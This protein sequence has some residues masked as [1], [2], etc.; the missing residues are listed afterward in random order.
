MRCRLVF[1]VLS[2]LTASCANSLGPPATVTGVWAAAFHIPGS[3][4]VLNLTQPDGAVSGSGTY[5]GEA[6]PSGTLQVTGSYAAPHVTLALRYDYGLTRNYDG[7]VLDAHQMTG[8]I[9]DS[10]GFTGTLTLIRQ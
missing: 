8:T 3:S 6:G 7:A 2:L 4:L 9:S 10:T 1:L 5:T